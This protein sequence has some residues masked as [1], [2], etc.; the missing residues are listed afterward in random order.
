MDFTPFLPGINGALKTLAELL[1]FPFIGIP[2]KAKFAIGQNDAARLKIVFDNTEVVSTVELTE[3]LDNFIFA[4]N[5]GLEAEKTLSSRAANTANV[6]EAFVEA[7]LFK[8]VS[9]EK[10]GRLIDL[11]ISEITFKSPLE[12]AFIGV[13][14][15]FTFA[16]IFS[17]GELEIKATGIKA[18]LPSL[19]KGISSLK[20]ALHKGNTLKVG[21]KRQT[22]TLPE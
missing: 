17:G 4:Y 5:I 22:P 16:V 20:S 3:F 15:A 18:K 8:T 6:T 21:K 11:Q 1:G 12:I 13:S 9:N 14:S 19:G 10:E 2:E 7:A